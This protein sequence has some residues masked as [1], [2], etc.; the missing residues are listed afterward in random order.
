MYPNKETAL[1]LL[2]E[3]EK[4]N[5]GPWAAHCGHVAQCAEK[6]A[7]LCGLDPEKAFVLGLLHDIGRKFGPSQFRHVTDGYSYMT[8]LGYDEV[9]RVCLTHSFSIQKIQ[10]YIGKF[11]VPPEEAKRFEAI[12]CRISYDDY[13]RLIQLCDSLAG[14]QGVTTMEER[15][16]DVKCRYGNY[17]EEKWNANLGLKTYFEKKIGQDLY[18]VIRE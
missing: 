6:I 14:A 7:A 12:L 16:G 17:P 9:A 4:S 18:Q 11:D 1:L 3:G 2:N 5:P 13:D 10:D 8:E 15:M